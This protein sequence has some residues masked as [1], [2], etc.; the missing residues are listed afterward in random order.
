[1]IETK[2]IPEVNKPKLETDHRVLVVR[3]LSGEWSYGGKPKDYAEYDGC[4][5]FWVWLGSAFDWAKAVKKA[6]SWRSAKNRRLT[7]NG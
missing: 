4:E 1:M 3:F 7:K 2:D 6:Q 5:L